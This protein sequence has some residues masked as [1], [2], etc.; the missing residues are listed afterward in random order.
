M[1]NVKKLSCSEFLKSEFSKQGSVL[2]LY[3]LVCIFT[4]LHASL[5]KGEVVTEHEQ[6]EVPEC[7]SLQQLHLQQAVTGK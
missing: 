5:L 7:S 4:A 1:H 2:F 6:Q 3:L